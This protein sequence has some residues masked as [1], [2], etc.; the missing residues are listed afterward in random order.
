M[1]CNGVINK[2]FYNF[3]NIETVAH[4]I[5]QNLVQVITL[6]PSDRPQHSAKLI[7]PYCFDDISVIHNT[8]WIISTFDHHLQNSHKGGEKQ[9]SKNANEIMPGFADLNLNRNS[10]NHRN[11]GQ[12]SRGN[13]RNTSFKLSC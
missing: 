9:E 3:Q 4:R 6:N 11:G 13:S 8:C 1:L 10:F 12:M 2:H 5:S 7:C